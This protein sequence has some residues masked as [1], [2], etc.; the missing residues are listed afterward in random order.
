MI[1]EIAP[2][3][4]GMHTYI[5]LKFPMYGSVN[6]LCGVCGISTDITEAYTKNRKKTKYFNPATSLQVIVLYLT[7]ARV[8]L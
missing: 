1:E 8:L 3:D 7:G 2:Q 4:D 6:G 5:S